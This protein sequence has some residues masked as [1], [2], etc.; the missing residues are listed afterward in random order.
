M[1]SLLWPRFE[2]E[3]IFVPSCFGMLKKGKLK[4]ITLCI[5]DEV[6]L[7]REKRGRETSYH[8]CVRD[9]KLDILAPCVFRIIKE[10]KNNYDW[11]YASLGGEGE[12]GRTEL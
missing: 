10:R 11:F 5:D 12:R 2:T 3:Y 1:L 4:L 6:S 8:Y 7:G 9:L